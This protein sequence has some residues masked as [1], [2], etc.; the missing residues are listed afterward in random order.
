MYKLVITEL[1]QKDLDSVV[2]YI[3]VQLANPIAA[4]GLLDEIEKC[5][6]S[7][8]SNPLIYAKS[9]DARLEKSGYR[10]ALV[11]SYI[12]SFKVFEEEKKVIVYRI[13]YGAR[14][15]LKLL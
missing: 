3:A 8:Q 10:K 15:Y 11:K 12:L 7:L 4:G 5:Y 13:L 9:S 14:D 1:A 2:E 6:S